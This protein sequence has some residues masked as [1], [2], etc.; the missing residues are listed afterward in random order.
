[1]GIYHVPLPAEYFSAISFCV[2]CYVWGALSVGW[3]FMVPLYCGWS[4]IAVGGIG[5][6]DCQG[7]LVRGACTCVLVGGARSLLSG[8]QL[9][10]Q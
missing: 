5:L 2:D 4:L 10:V 7:F 3:K 6:V 8:V 9:S 1:M